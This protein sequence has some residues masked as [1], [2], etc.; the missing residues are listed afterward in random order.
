MRSAPGL[1]SMVW[2]CR[3]LTALL[4]WAGFPT[5]MLGQPKDVDRSHHSTE[6]WALPWTVL[7]IAPDG[8]WGVAT[9]TYSYQA[10]AGAIAN[11]KRMYQKEIG[12]GHQSTTTRAGWSLA[13]RC[14]NQ[15][16]IV[17]AK[18]LADAI[19]AAADRETILRQVYRPDMPTRINVLTVNP[20]GIV[21]RY[22]SETSWSASA[23]LPASTTNRLVP[24]H[25][26]R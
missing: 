23:I 13:V 16:I 4:L 17:A 11:C 1:S 9:E 12:C 3:F 20:Q 10:L 2:T 24:E 26:E 18:L 6:D 25:F 15:N 19:Q 5:S 21:T 22:N 8:S 14:G 7:T